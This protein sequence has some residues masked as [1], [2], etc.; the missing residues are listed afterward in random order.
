MMQQSA[1]VEEPYDCQK[2]GAGENCDRLLLHHAVLRKQYRCRE[3]QI[4]RN[5]AKKRNRLQVNFARA[6]TV[7]ESHAQRKVAHRRR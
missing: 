7:H 1:V 4:D 6:R 5:S 2:R 3:S